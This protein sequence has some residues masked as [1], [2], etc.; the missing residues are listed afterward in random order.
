MV[1]ALL[2]LGNSTTGA[3]DDM[4]SSLAVQHHRRYEGLPWQP[5][6][7]VRCTT[8]GAAKAGRA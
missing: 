4:A 2:S 8:S 1:D 3:T 7:R 6:R 5:P